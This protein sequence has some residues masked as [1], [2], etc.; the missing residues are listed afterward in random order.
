MVVSVFI[1]HAG[2]WVAWPAVK[3]L[4]DAGASDRELQNIRTIAIQVAGVREVHSIRTRYV[5]G[6]LQVDLHV[7]VDGYLSV[8][9]GHSISESVQE[10]LLD[11]GPDVVDSV[12]HLEP[13]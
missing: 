1:M 7:L 12:V 5:E 6:S 8:S 11:E 9:E 13:A 3:E 2:W 10:R 4:V